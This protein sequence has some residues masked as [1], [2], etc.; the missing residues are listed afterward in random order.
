MLTRPTTRPC[1]SF[2]YYLLVSANPSG[3]GKNGGPSLTRTGD[4]TIMS[5]ML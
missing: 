5:R 4:L 1:L 3:L 2:L